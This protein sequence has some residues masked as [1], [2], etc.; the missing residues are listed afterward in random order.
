LLPS[1]HPPMPSSVRIL[2]HGT[3]Q[4]VFFRASIKT[5]ARRLGLVGWVRN[6]LDGG[7]EAVAQGPRET[8]EELVRWCHVG[9]PMS[10]VDEVEVDW[11]EVDKLEFDA[12]V[13]GRSVEGEG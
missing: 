4:G 7:V 6:R 11:S 13:V 2:V 5:E 3:V 12:F 1:S 8:L 10:K 9:P